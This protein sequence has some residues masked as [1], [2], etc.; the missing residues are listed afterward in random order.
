MANVLD[1]ADLADDA[2]WG[3]N[4]STGESLVWPAQV[5]FFL[6]AM[7]PS[8]LS[9]PGPSCVVTVHLLSLAVGGR[10]VLHGL[11]ALA[12]HI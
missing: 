2:G 8:C 6:Q 7:P 4:A 9:S 5:A 12:A 10:A 3:E 1:S 11:R